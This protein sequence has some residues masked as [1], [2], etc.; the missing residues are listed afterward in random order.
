MNNRKHN[1]ALN[2]IS[3]LAFQITTIV[4][5]FILPRLIL[6]FFGSEV[7]G[8]VNSITQ[9]LGIITFMELGIGA[10]VQSSL[11]KPLAEKDYN[12]ISKIYVSA[13]RFFK[14]IAKV[15]VAYV[16]FLIIFYPKFSHQHF[17]WA[18][19]AILI[20][21]IS[22][23]MFAQYYF[24]I[25]NQLLLNADQHGYIQYNIQTAT[26][27]INTIASAV[28]I[29][30]GF[31]IQVVKL[32]TSIIYLLRPL[33]LNI[34]VKKHY[35]INTKITYDKE[36]IQQKW[37]GIAQHVA[38][39]ILQSTDNIV[40]TLFSS[41]ANVSIYSVYNL[42]KQL[43]ISLTNGF[44]PLLGDLWARKESDELLKT[45]GW[46]EWLVH[47]GTVLLFG[48]TSILVVPFISIYTR[49]VTDA[50]YYQP[51][52]AILISAANAGHCLRLPYNMMIFAGGHYKQT[53]SNYIISAV[54][55][56]VISIMMVRKFGLMGVAIGTLISMMYQTIWMAWYTSRNLI[57]WP[58]KKFVKQLIIDLFTV[59]IMFLATNQFTMK[60]INYLS[61]GVL[62][63]KVLVTSIFIVL[64]IN[65]IFYPNR[66]FQ[67]VR[68]MRKFLVRKN[69]DRKIK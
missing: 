15:L 59:L 54:L 22:I 40:L 62:A 5:G 49:G 18:Y 8:L 14:T 65:F 3:S 27:I 20:I 67:L 55:N 25:V 47:T 43:L 34:Y 29:N 48:C 7:N 39:V 2:T 4:C 38:Y 60:S 31:S 21:A 24:G 52:F 66:S 26:L 30:F 37:N 51:V 46:F 42:V 53:Q 13:S 50:D 33:L 36:P 9:F 69:Q 6:S 28:L 11:Y 68:K 35:N 45:F 63:I 32:S 1:L 44:Q 10:V 61:W 12:Q 23:S 17:G 56:I 64:I 58:F 19:N 41:L 57:R 16:I